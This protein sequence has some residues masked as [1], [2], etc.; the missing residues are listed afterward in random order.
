MIGTAGTTATGAVDPLE[1]IADVAEAERL[2]LH[3][4]GAY[5]APAAADPASRPLFSGLQRADSLCVDAHKWL[6]VPV[7]CGA[8]LMR[9]PDAGP[10]AFGAADAAYVRILTDEAAE[11]FAFWDH[12]LERRRRFR[13]LKLWMTLRYYGGR[14]LAAA[15]THDIAMAE[16]M[17]A[18]VRTSGELELLAEPGLSVCFFARPPGMADAA[19]DQPT[20]GCGGVAPR[21]ARLLS[22]SRRRPLACG[23]HHNFPATHN[24][25]ERTLA[26]VCELGDR[27]APQRR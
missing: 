7:D 10:K 24:N 27:V 26:L 23:L 16:H 13:A 17:A 19:L 4:D 22:R 11:S 15:I 1:A 8:L 5:G 25:V 12:G 3:V 14:R 21:R 18:H 20:S 6:Y 9:S 2:W